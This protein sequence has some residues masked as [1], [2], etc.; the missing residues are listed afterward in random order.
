MSFRKSLSALLLATTLVVTGDTQQTPS[1]HTLRVCHDK[2]GVPTSFQNEFSNA[3]QQTKSFYDDHGVDIKE[4]KTDCLNIEYATA[5]DWYQNRFTPA[6]DTLYTLPD[7]IRNHTY[8][9][10]DEDN[11]ETIGD[12]IAAFQADIKAHGVTYTDALSSKKGRRRY[13][14]L[15]EL[16]HHNPQDNTITI[17]PYNT[18]TASVQNNTPLKHA[19][20]YTLAHEIGHHLLLPHPGDWKQETDATLFHAKDYH[21]TNVMSKMSIDTANTEYGYTLSKTQKQ[22]AHTFLN[23]DSQLHTYQDS[24]DKALDAYWENRYPSTSRA[25]YTSK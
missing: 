25:Q 20:S 7:S 17:K 1:Q 12:S 14:R 21:P 16:A 2:I 15:H 22:L 9:K 23:D 8:I 19:A 10:L 4:T 3:W 11:P 13:K 24:S 18:I 6:N 5:I